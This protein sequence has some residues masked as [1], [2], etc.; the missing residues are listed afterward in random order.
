MATVTRKNIKSA[1]TIGG[2]PA[3]NVAALNFSLETDAAG[4]WVGSDQATAIAIADKL[5]LG[6][7][8]AGMLVTDYTARISDT[9]TAATTMKIGFEYVDG[10]DMAGAFAQDDDYFCAATTMATAAILKPTNT[11]VRPICFPKDVFLT[12]VNAGAAHASVGILDI[13]ITGVLVG[14]A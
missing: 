1:P 6:I 12:L 14:L 4:V 5:R 8:P 2:T 9:F 11:A 7:I 3:G 10:V 13:T